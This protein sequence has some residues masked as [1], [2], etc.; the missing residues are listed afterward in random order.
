VHNFT[1][2]GLGEEHWLK[3]RRIFWPLRDKV[4]ENKKL[5]NQK[6]HDFYSP[7]ILVVISRSMRW[8]EHLAY[9][10]QKR[11]AYRVLVRNGD[12]KRALG[13]PRHRW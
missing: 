6:L 7:N 5:L 2:K 12:R 4:T 3:V 13:R 1:A 9:V 10:G 11:N 8:Q